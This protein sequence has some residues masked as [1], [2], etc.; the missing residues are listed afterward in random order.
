MSK[1]KSFEID[2]LI[3][4]SKVA[5]WSGGSAIVAVLLA[6]TQNLEVDGSFALL[7]PVINSVLYAANRFF[8][9]KA[10]Q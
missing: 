1:R 5:L 3:S 10:V 6:Y 9:E 2:D 4:V 8:K 7:I